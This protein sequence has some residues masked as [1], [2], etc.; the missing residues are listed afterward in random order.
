MLIE[1]PLLLTKKLSYQAK[2]DRGTTG[3]HYHGGGTLAAANPTATAAPIRACS[4]ASETAPRA[5]AA[6]GPHWGVILGALV[7]SPRYP[8][9]PI[10][11]AIGRHWRRPLQSRRT[12]C[13][14][15]GQRLRP[16][17][18]RA[19]SKHS[20]RSSWRTPSS[21][22]RLGKILDARTAARVALRRRR[23]RP[24]AANWRTC[25]SR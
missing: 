16:G 20:A 6:P 1:V 24:A 10:N 18:A 19:K 4:F 22:L 2:N 7:E 12:A 25:P 3:A 23:R 13:F 15:E 11:E 21:W 9:L 14:V 8:T 17:G 5:P